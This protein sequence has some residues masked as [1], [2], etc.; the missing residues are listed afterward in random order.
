MPN[1]PQALKKKFD[2]TKS[3]NFQRGS[4]RGRDHP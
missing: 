2:K 3:N 1:I 4:R